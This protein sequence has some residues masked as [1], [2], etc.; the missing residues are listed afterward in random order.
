M[1][2]EPSPYTTS[3]CSLCIPSTAASGRTSPDDEFRSPSTPRES[4]ANPHHKPALKPRTSP[5]K[6]SFLRIHHHHTM[7]Y[8]TRNAL[9][10]R[11]SSWTVLPLYLYLD[12]RHFNVV[13]SLFPILSCNGRLLAKFH[14]E[15]PNTTKKS[16]VEVH[17]GA[18]YQFAFF[19]RK[20]DTRHVVLL[21]KREYIPQATSRP[22]SL[23]IPP[24][25]NLQDPT[26]LPSRRPHSTLKRKATNDAG[27]VLPEKETRRST[28]ARSEVNYA[29]DMVSPPPLQHDDDSVL[30]LQ[31]EPVPQ[32]ALFLDDGYEE[33]RIRERAPTSP[34]IQVKAEPQDPVPMGIPARS[35]AEKAEMYAGA[36]ESLDRTTMDTGYEDIA[37][38]L[39]EAGEREASEEL[40]TFRPVNDEEDEEKKDTKMDVKPLMRMS[41]KGLFP[42]T[43]VSATLAGIQKLII[44]LIFPSRSGFS[45]SSRHLVLIIEPYPALTAASK[46]SARARSTYASRSM[47]RATESRARGSMSTIG[48][49][50]GR[51]E[52][53][54]IIPNSRSGGTGSLSVFQSATPALPSMRAG[55]IAHQT[56]TPNSRSG[57]G[58]RGVGS[59]PFRMSATPARSARNGAAGTPLFRDMTPMSEFGG[60]EA[61]STRNGDTALFGEEEGSS[62]EEDKE[63]R[64]RARGSSYA[65]WRGSSVIGGQETSR[66]PPTR[67]APAS[68]SDDSD[69]LAGYEDLPSSDD[70]DAQEIAQAR[71]LMALSQRLQ[72]NTSGREG[73]GGMSGAGRVVDAGE[74]GQGIGDDDTFG[75]GE[76]E[77]EGEYGRDDV[78]G[79]DA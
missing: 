55:G 59:T 62:E 40:I 75:D 66:P 4:N 33:S 78:G 45:I 63:W 19:F 12:E 26:D 51:E 8:S 7:P 70:E 43:M 34:L 14:A 72:G 18:T 21:K 73:I 3:L 60:G 42:I 29:Q 48:Q 56:P 6:T 23:A 1:M 11:I 53:T 24:K 69:S 35:A 65:P 41:Y 17:R 49:G 77:G 67:G 44:R 9:Y 28:R 61:E 71:R 74:L 2:R 50:L 47:S 36:H 20:T 16:T 22:R 52:M 38:G 31:G 79:A 27:A 32:P 64:R 76:G 5:A 15:D 54:P 13:D 10:L 39:P 25:P 46:P 30:S 58:T 37:D 57:G 68:D